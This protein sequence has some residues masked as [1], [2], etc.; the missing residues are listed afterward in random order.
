MTDTLI[1]AGPL[2]AVMNRNDQHHRA[3][4]EIIQSLD[5]AFYTTLPVLTE[6]MYVTQAR[7][8]WRAQNALWR[9]VLRGDLM[10]EHPSGTDLSRMYE[11]ME[12]Y[13]DRPMDFADASLVALA[14]RL[15]LDKI[16]T[17]DRQDF[18]VY[19]LRGK[20]AFKIIGP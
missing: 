19:R 18:S 13:R 17:V 6:A 8:G 2:I 11:L 20:K 5:S 4:S 9:L 10:L 15:S 7:L 14:E 3:C 16:F 12:S 1:D